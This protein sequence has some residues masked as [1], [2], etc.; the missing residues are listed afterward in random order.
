MKV[1]PAAERAQTRLEEPGVAAADFRAEA[2]VWRPP[3]N[4]FSGELRL[5]HRLGRLPTGVLL[6]RNS[7]HLGWSV[8]A[9]QLALWSKTEIRLW[10]DALHRWE[11]GSVTLG[12]GQSSVSAA[13]LRPRSSAVTI[14]VQFGIQDNQATDRPPTKV[15]GFTVANAMTTAITFQYAD[16]GTEAFS[17]QI[18]FEAETPLHVDDEFVWQVL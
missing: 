2:I 4:G 12:S 16:H 10:I 6:L 5:A 7:L 18:H 11:S 1:W 3:E 14:R 9:A 8:P 13:L 17:Q 15:S